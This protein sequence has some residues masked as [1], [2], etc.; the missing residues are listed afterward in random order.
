M[1]NQEIKR[2]YYKNILKEHEE[3]KRAVESVKEVF[4]HLKSAETETADV[5][6]PSQKLASALRDFQSHLLQHFALEEQNG[7][8]M[9]AADEAPQYA[10]RLEELQLQHGEML[11]RIT[12]LRRRVRSNTGTE[13]AEVWSQMSATFES[14]LGELNRHETAENEIVQQAFDEDT[15]AAD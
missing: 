10:Q 5:Y 2:G 11:G 9:E 7:Y 13:P 6:V 12:D 8:L 14:F 4:S 3:I 1:A 15:G